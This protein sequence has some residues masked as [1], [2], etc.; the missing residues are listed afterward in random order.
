M[1]LQWAN[2]DLVVK[3]ADPKMPFVRVVYLPACCFDAP[4]VP[5]N[6]LFP[7]EALEATGR[8]WEFLVHNPHWD[9]DKETCKANIAPVKFIDENGKAM[10]EEPR[11]KSTPG[12]E[13]EKVPPIQTLPC[14]ILK[15][16]GWSPAKTEKTADG[17]SRGAKS[18]H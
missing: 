2:E 8:E 13:V 11:F 4:P 12:A 10:K 3:T 15:V 14:F 1:H 17:T 16:R 7:H 18:N 6:D 9:W 5:V